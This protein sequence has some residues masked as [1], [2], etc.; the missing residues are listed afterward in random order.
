MVLRLRLLAS[1]LLGGGW[2][3]AILCRGAQTLAQRP[4]LNLGFARSTP[5]PTGFLVGIALV[6]GVLSGGCS[7][8][9]LVPRNEQLT[10]D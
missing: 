3:L 8:A 4:S 2:L 10:G 9:L 5:L 6:I 7:A 1:S